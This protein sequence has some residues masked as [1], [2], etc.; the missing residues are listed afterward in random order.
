MCHLRKNVNLPNKKK[1]LT[2]LA[3]SGAQV[4]GVSTDTFVRIEIKILNFPQIS[5]F[6]SHSVCNIL[7]VFGF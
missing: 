5:K 6:L 7:V 1:N 4:G 3:V 2:L